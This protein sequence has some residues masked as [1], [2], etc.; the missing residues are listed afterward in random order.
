MSSNDKNYILLFDSKVPNKITVEDIEGNQSQRSV[1]FYTK[2]EACNFDILESFYEEN[3]HYPEGGYS[4]IE[5]LSPL[6]FEYDILKTALESTFNGQIEILVQQLKQIQVIKIEKIFNKTVFD[7]FKDELQIT[8]K[9]IPDI[10]WPR[11]YPNNKKPT[12]LQNKE[13]KT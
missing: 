12:L 2:E 10:P 6:D 3:Q 5:K 11:L 4:R 7:K 9:N 13:T 1:E 8:L